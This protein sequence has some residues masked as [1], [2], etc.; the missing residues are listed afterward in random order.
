MRTTD[1]IVADIEAFLPI[2][3]DWRALD[4][5]L[6]ELWGAGVLEQ[7]LPTLFGVFERSPDDDGAG[8]LWGIVHG[9]ES[10][11]FDYEV[12]L[13]NS[14]GRQTSFMGN[15]LLNRLVKARAAPTNAPAPTWLNPAP[16]SPKALQDLEREVGPL[17]SSYLSASAGGTAGRS[18]CV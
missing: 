8:V 17:P 4:E 10:L 18:G 6:G 13:R 3:G 1:A 7:H 15:V 16:A 12:P 2:D 14:L 11:P 9:V 5:L